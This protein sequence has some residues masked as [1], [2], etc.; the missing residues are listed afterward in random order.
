MYCKVSCHNF[1][2]HLLQP[3]KINMKIE[4]P[5]TYEV[6]LVIW[7]LKSN[8]VC[9]MLIHMQIV[10]VCGEGA[11]NERNATK[12]CHL[13]KGSSTMCSHTSPPIDA[14]YWTV[15]LGNFWASSS[16]QS[17]FCIRWLSLVSPLQEIFGQ[18]LRNDQETKNWLKGLAVTF[19]DKGLIPWYDKCL[20]LHADHVEM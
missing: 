2:S 4:N 20:K 11:M 12:W 19:L 16:I 7:F 13:F 9:L 8:N 17:H 18:R 1:F 10:E 3:L 14:Q 15:Q 5:A 6:Q